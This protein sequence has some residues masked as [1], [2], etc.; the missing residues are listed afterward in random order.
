MLVSFFLSSSCYLTLTFPHKHSAL[1]KF[2]LIKVLSERKLWD[3]KFDHDP[4]IKIKSIKHSKEHNNNREVL[5]KVVSKKRHKVHNSHNFLELS[6]GHLNKKQVII[7]KW[8]YKSRSKKSRPD[9]ISRICVVLIIKPI[10][11]RDPQSE[12]SDVSCAE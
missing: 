11:P 2:P 5:R 1:I 10:R 9:Q 6:P 8:L 3:S 4:R 7:Y 12:Q